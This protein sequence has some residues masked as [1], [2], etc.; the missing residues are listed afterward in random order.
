MIGIASSAVN[1]LAAG[2][3]TTATLLTTGST[4]GY[5]RTILGIEAIVE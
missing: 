5:D 4:S 3:T 1:D 2:Q